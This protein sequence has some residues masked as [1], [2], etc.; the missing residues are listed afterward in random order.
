MDRFIGGDDDLH[1]WSGGIELLTRLGM[2]GVEVEAG[3]NPSGGLR[4]SC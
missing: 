1:T 4:C 2:H 3:N